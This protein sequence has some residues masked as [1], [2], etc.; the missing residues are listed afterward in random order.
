MIGQISRS[1]R[2]LFLVTGFQFVIA[3]G[4]AKSGAEEPAADVTKGIVPRARIIVDNDFGGDPDGLFQLAHHLLSPSVEVRGVVGSQ[5]HEGGFYGSPG[6]ATHAC[7]KAKRLLETMRLAEQITVYEGANTKLRDAR[8]PIESAGARFIVDEAM[9]ED[10][11]LPLYVVCGAGL[12]NV[13]SACLLEPKIAE[14]LTIVWIGGPE[15]AGQALPPSG[16]KHTEYNLGIDIVAGQVVFNDS[17]VPIWQVPRNAYRQALVSNSEL[18]HRVDG[19]SATG[20]FLMAELADL[21]RRSKYSLGEAYVLG[22]SPLVLLT[23]LQTAWAPDAS[24]SEYVVLPAPRI[25]DAGRYEPNPAGREIRVYT[26][27]DI[28]LMMEDFYAKVALGGE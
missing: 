4:A 7:E 11:R 26:R 5:H 6:T 16:D 9:R 12:T 14:R 3:C 21:M 1:M 24:S 23:A 19:E 2:Y 22:D 25:N 27:L 13:A 10:S 20:R 17:Q 18:Q 8:T 15:Y 28:R